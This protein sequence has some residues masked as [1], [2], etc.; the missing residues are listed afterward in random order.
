METENIFDIYEPTKYYY[1]KKKEDN[2]IASLSTSTANNLN[3]NGSKLTFEI[4][5]TSSWLYLPRA[6]L[7]CDFKLQNNA[8]NAINTSVLE[9]NFFPRMFSQMILEAGSNQ[10]ETIINPGEFD[11]MLKSVLYPKDFTDNSGWIPDENDGNA[12]NIVTTADGADQ[13]TT[14][15]LANAL[16]TCK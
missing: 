14:Q 3:T 11:T 4:N 13:A 7:R 5:N 15:A 1:N 12:L 8:G 10:L 9:H 2:L 6:Y 16:K